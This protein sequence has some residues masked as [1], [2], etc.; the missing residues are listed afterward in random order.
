MER[1]RRSAWDAPKKRWRFWSAPSDLQTSS[2]TRTPTMKAPEAVCF[3]PEVQSAISCAIPM[4]AAPWHST[5]TRS[6]TWTRSRA[7]SCNYAQVYLLAGSSYAL[8]RLGRP[9]EARERLDRAFASLKELGSIRRTKIEAGSEVERALSALADHEAET[10]NVAG[11]IELY[12]DLLDRLAAWRESGDQ[13]GHYAVD[14]SRIHRS[15][16]ALQRRN[17]RA[18]LAAAMDARRLELWRHWDRKLPNNPFVLTHFFTS[19][20]RSDR[21]RSSARFAPSTSPAGA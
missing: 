7:S 2:C 18:D 11:A 15:M 14:L 6:G 1:I 21:A 12:Q 13:P 17:G 16:A 10:G 5:T 9:A 19:E 3:W 20:G 8:R 4:P